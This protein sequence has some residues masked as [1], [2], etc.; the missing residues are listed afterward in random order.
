MGEYH[1]IYLRML[2]PP[3]KK[4]MRAITIYTPTQITI[5]GLCAEELRCGEYFFLKTFFFFWKVHIDFHGIFR[6]ATNKTR[7]K[8]ARHGANSKINICSRRV[9]FSIQQLFVIINLWLSHTL[10][11]RIKKYFIH[12]TLEF[13]TVIDSWVWGEDSKAG[14][15]RANNLLAR[16][17]EYLRF[18][19]S[20][21]WSSEQD[22]MEKRSPINH[23]NK[24]EIKLWV[25]LV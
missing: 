21:K 10:R 16:I 8:K 4:E 6:G 3:N 17:A 22:T 2:F 20:S 18:L 7:G 24:T 14:K 12:F 11:E 23:F 15:L 9:L 5:V 25:L 13:A 19:Y 1:L